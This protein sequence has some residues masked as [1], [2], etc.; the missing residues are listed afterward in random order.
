MYLGVV[1]SFDFYVLT[2]SIMHIDGRLT[3]LSADYCGFLQ[4]GDSKT[5]LEHCF[6]GYTVTVWKFVSKI[7]DKFQ[8]GGAS[9]AQFSITPK[10]PPTL[11]APPPPPFPDFF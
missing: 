2:L 8:A 7:F 6:Q 4:N 3:N 5:T 1:L 9:C 11:T 10:T